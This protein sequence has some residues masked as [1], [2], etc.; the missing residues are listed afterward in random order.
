MS[1][2]IEKRMEEIP[3][4]LFVK[5]MGR[6]VY[7]KEYRVLMDISLSGKFKNYNADEFVELFKEGNHLHML[8]EWYYAM[9]DLEFYLNT[10]N[11]K[12]NLYKRLLIEITGLK[13]INKVIDSFRMSS[14]LDT[15]VCLIKAKAKETL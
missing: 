15:L 5:A 4:N 2:Y 3:R 14:N 9:S 13:D 7:M 12:L 1:T 11:E 10:S 6:K 8:Y